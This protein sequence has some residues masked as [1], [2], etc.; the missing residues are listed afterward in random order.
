LAGLCISA[1]EA[2]LI[3][4][5][6]LLTEAVKAN[7]RSA[8]AGAWLLDNFYSNEEQNRTAKGNWD[9]THEQIQANLE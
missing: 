9:P 7:R 1:N 4:A 6:H 2:I 3:N 5:H 8:P